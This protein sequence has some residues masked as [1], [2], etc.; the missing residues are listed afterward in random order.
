MERI[1]G[2]IKEIKND[3]K[4]LIKVTERL[5]TI[6]EEHERRSLSLEA[7]QG[8]LSKRLSPLEKNIFA[9]MLILGGLGSVIV[10]ITIQFVK[11]LF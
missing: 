3:L 11:K 8:E 5:T 9:I 10:G 1:I 4:E 7:R 6:V 2:D